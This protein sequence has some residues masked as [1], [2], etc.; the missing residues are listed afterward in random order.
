MTNRGLFCD[1]KSIK[2]D[3]A[4]SVPKNRVGDEIKI[5]EASFIL[6]SYAFFDQIEAK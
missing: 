6:L 1:E 4:K 3:A 2:L 5:D